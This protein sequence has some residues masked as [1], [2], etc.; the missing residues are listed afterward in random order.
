M[1]SR[2]MAAPSSA[3]GLGEPSWAVLMRTATHLAAFLPW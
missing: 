1:R 3:V 2:R